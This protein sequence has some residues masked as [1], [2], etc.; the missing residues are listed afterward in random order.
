MIQFYLFNVLSLVVWCTPM[1]VKTWHHLPHLKVM[2]PYSVY[3]QRSWLMSHEL[4]DRTKSTIDLANTITMVIEPLTPPALWIWWTHTTWRVGG[5]VHTFSEAAVK[6]FSCNQ[7]FKVVIIFSYQPL[8]VIK[9]G[10]PAGNNGGQSGVQCCRW[11]P[12]S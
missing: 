7:Y 9:L 5:L 12:I 2:L 1:W 8:C 10:L 3:I 6:R 11:V 4:R